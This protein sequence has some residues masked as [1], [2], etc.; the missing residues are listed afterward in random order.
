MILK[1]KKQIRN[2]Q[3]KEKEAQLESGII[4]QMKYR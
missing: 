1:L 4:M 2:E 3:K